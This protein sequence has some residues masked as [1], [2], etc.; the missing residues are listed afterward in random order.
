MPRPRQA[1]E[2]VADAKRALARP[3][4]YHVRLRYLFHDR[5]PN[6]S[7][8]ERCWCCGS[9]R[10]HIVEDRL[11][12]EFLITSTGTRRARSQVRDRPRFDELAAAAPTL[13]IKLQ[14]PIWQDEDGAT[15]LDVLEDLTTP[16]W[17]LGGGGRG[18]KTHW[19]T[20]VLTHRW[21]YRGAAGAEFAA[22]APKMDQAHLVLRKLVKGEAKGGRR[23]PPILP[24][25]L[26]LS[27][28]ANTRSIDQRIVLYDGS[29]IWLTHTK[30][31]DHFHGHS[32]V[33][34]TWTEAHA[35]R[36]EETYNVVRTRL[37]DTGGQL[38]LDS[39]PSADFNHW[40]R[41]AVL[42]AV[43]DEDRR[44]RL[45]ETVERLHRKITFHSSRNVWVDPKVVARTRE[46]IARKDP[47]AAKRLVD[48]IWTKS[49]TIFG[50]HF[51]ED[52]HVVDC[53]EGDLGYLG[54]PDITRKVTQ[55]YFGKPLAWM[56]APHRGPRQDLRP[57]QQA[58]DLGRLLPPLR[59]DL[60]RRRVRQAHRHGRRGQVPQGRRAGDR[61]QRQPQREA[62][63]EGG[64]R[65]PSRTTGAQASS[66]SR[67][68]PRRRSPRTPTAR[69]PQR[70]CGC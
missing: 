64:A 48:G 25:E 44:E 53:P 18:G 9:H 69:T 37:I 12:D 38:F 50:E 39:T 58:R 51:D 28:P 2:L 11:R 17:M 61:R 36:H 14:I 70:S 68:S 15:P 33:D 54:L 52:V 59:P 31:D 34:A 35:C 49:D 45:G 16:I 4:T 22:I 57:V 65:R 30:S 63:L 66:A 23:L 41:E 56:E 60:R 13:D 43:D 29:Y 8:A 5:A 26:V 62:P 1:T 67:T 32:F 7:L 6:P 40:L 27:Y 19:N 46:S 20:I 10:A 47:A 42:A 55:K 3:L 21:L 24:P